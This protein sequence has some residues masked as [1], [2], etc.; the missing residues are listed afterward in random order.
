MDA[1]P[2]PN[3]VSIKLDKPGRLLVIDWADGIRNSYPFPLLRA[4]CPS[5]GERTARENANPD[6]LAVLPKMPSHDIADLRLV[7][8]YALCPTWTD[9]HSAGIYTWEFLRKLGD[10]PGVESTALA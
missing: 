8:N 5:A 4:H 3:P 9:G 7:G 2:V 6:P 10:L 1:E